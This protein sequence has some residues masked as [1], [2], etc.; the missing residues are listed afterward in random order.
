MRGARSVPESSHQDALAAPEARRPGSVR[1][2]LITAFVLVAILLAVLLWFPPAATVG[3]LTLAI[4]A[5]AWEWSA[6]VRPD[7][8]AIRFAFVLLIAIALPI[9]WRCTPTQESLLLVLGASTLWWLLALAW[10]LAAPTRVNAWSA[11][12]AGVLALVPAWLALMRLRYVLQGG[13]WT[14]FVLAL[15]WLADTSAFFIGRRFG[16][17]KLAPRVSPGKTWEGVLAGMASAALVG[18]LGARLFHW[19]SPAFIALCLAV[20]AVSIV[21]DLTESMLKRHVGIKDSGYLIPGHGGVLDRI[22]SV[23]AAAPVFLLALM[24]GGVAP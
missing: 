5:G 12:L 16:R 3:V 6:F 14:V 19:P 8:M 15:V 22:D 17:V 20:V 21:G 7:S 10:I 9:A 2:R 24:C 13:E 23:L 4:L 18:A 1:T 11:G